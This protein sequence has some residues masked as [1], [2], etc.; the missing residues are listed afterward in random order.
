MV[1]VAFAPALYLDT[2]IRAGRARDW[3]DT[4]PPYVP[5]AGVAGTVAEVGD[6]VD[7]GWV[8]RRVVADTQETGG[9]AQQ[10]VVDADALVVVPDG[11]GLAEAAALLHDGRTALRLI[12]VTAPQPGEWALVL[13]AAGGM[14]AL[15]VQLARA[16]GARVIGAVG[17]ESRKQALV[18][19]LDAMPVDYSRPDWTADVRELTGGVGVDVLL[20]GIGGAIGTAAF[21]LAAPGARFSAH[22]TPAG[23]FARIDRRSAAARGVVVTGIECAQ[24]AP[25]EARE[26]VERALE[27]AA[28]GRLRPI[29]GQRFP[30]DRAADAHRAIESRH[31]FGKT[32][33]EA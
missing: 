8:G 22:G 24:I 11:V 23:G 7:P 3:F 28:A 6:G 29:I 25:D 30:L 5:G 19:D 17:S 31:V 33:L 20:D 4:A 10:V 9:Y 12:D 32:L 15:L 26:L 21:D 14:G 2:Q 16:A 27:E 18:R 13:G 1:E